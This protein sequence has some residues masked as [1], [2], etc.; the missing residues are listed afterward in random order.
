MNFLKAFNAEE[1]K[2]SIFLILSLRKLKETVSVLSQELI[3]TH[4]RPTGFPSDAE[5]PAFPVVE[6]A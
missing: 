2:R 5:G 6:T 4:T 3:P 1:E